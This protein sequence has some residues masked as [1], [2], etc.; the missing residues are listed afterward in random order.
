MNIVLWGAGGLFKITEHEFF[1][2]CI[3]WDFE[4]LIQQVKLSLY[5]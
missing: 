2:E 3:P 5:H 1:F 4:L